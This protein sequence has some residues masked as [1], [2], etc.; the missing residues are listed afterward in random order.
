MLLNQQCLI[1]PQTLQD[2]FPLSSEAKA[3]VAHNRHIIS[4]ILQ[5]KDDRFLIIVGPCSIHDPDAAREYAELLHQAIKQYSQELFI[6]MRV[7]FEK[8]RTTG[9]WKGLISD[10]FLNGS[11]DVN[12]GLRLARKLLQD[13]NALGIPLGTEFLD[14][15]VP[16]YLCDLISWTAIGAR[17]SASQIHRELAS[18]LPIP[19][20]F[21]NSM[22]GNI[23][24]AIDGITV[25]SQPQSMLT[26]NQEGAP[27]LIRTN[28]NKLGHLILR[29][30]E[31]GPN[32]EL[33][34]I[35]YAEQ[36]L[37]EAHVLSSLIIDCSHGNSMKNHEQQGLVLD[38]VIHNMQ[39]SKIIKGIMIESNLI[40]G[41]QTLNSHSSLTYGQSITDGCLSW[42]ETLPL[43]EKLAI[44]KQQRL[45]VFTI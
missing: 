41:K 29:G 30:G 34:H 20:G 13:L 6:V 19:V 12:T 31:Q 2:E 17:T 24:I 11:F 5:G 26:L 1:T 18:G 44:H 23:K 7:Y 40:A 25:A 16:P 32:Y 22:D 39:H 15:I 10:P 42:Q 28:G 33:K 45:E 35:R 38:T 3:T 43:L 8:P 14:T 21:K 27:I 36:L 4:Q 37:N 9:G